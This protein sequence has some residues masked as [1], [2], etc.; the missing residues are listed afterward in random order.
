MEWDSGTFLHTCCFTRDITER[1]QSE[2]ERANLLMQ[3]P[4]ATALLVGPEHRFELANPLYRAMV[5]RD[6]VGKK[7]LE[8]F[9][10]LAD[11][12]LPT[13]LDHVYQTGEPFVANDMLVRLYRNQGAVAEECFFKFNLE[14]IRNRAGKIYGMMAVAIEVTEQVRARRAARDYAGATAHARR[15]DT[16]AGMD[17]A[18]RRMD[19][20]LQRALVRLYGHHAGTDG[21]LGMAVRSRSER[22]AQSNGE[23]DRFNRDGRHL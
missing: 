5:G 1:K 13:I 11:T 7:Y 20:L 23:L 9:P 14:P 8:A 4:V 3:A 15:L 19:R 16:D 2:T 12:E 10:E 21:R 6:V 22:T 18:S 17:R